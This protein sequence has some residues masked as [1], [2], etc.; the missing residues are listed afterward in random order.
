M[1]NNTFDL[2]IVGA[3]AAGLMAAAEA[4]HFKLKVL[5]LE[6]Q[7]E[8]GLKILMCG[9]GRCN[10]TNVKVTEKDY[11]AGCE[12]TLR[13]VLKNFSTQDVLRFFEQWQAPLAL[14]EDGC[15]FS[16]DGSART[17]L[18][19]LM[20]AAQS[21][22]AQIRLGAKV[23]SLAVQDGKFNVVAGGQVEQS[24]SVLITTG[25]LSYPLTGSDGSGY[26]LA[27]RFGHRL[28]P[29]RPALTPLMASSE[30]FTSLSGIV[31]NVG[32][33]LWVGGKKVHTVKGPLLFTHHGFSG[34][35]ALEMSRAWVDG[36]AKK[37]EVKIDFFPQEKLPGADFLF[38]GTGPREKSLK[39]LLT[40]WLPERLVVILLGAAGVD[41]LKRPG[42]SEVSKNDRHA[43]ER[44]LRAF[45]LPIKDTMGYAKAEITSGGVD[46]KELKGASLE[47]RLQE[48]LYFAGEV[49]DVDGRI[50]GFNLHWAWASAVSA[51]RV[52]A[53]K[54]KS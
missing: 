32:L 5:V 48:G 50:G 17:V 24:R 51:A 39:N 35:A 36:R 53:K 29:S 12:H 26:K 10:A 18:K 11:H 3:G 20:A 34:P 54:V 46:L 25:G 43:I 37:G 49:I 30:M 9:G 1:E 13:H 4:S 7:K 19:A 6:G 42:M 8:P 14:Q 27:E 21:G 15:Y 28:V 47:S 33:N 38:Q 2:I 44:V 52:I 16:A 22:G 23:S 31:V 41:G 45:P 40:A